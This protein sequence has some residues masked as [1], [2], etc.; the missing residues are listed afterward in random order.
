MVREDFTNTFF[1]NVCHI[2]ILAGGSNNLAYILGAKNTHIYKIFIIRFADFFL[3]MINAG[4]VFITYREL[5]THG[6]YVTG[7]WEQMLSEATRN[8]NSSRKYCSL[9]EQ[10][11]RNHTFKRARSQIQAC[12][13][14]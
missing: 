13:W 7:L 9:W 2:H 1:F 11:C 3:K 6:S 14:G 8:V 4:Y 5:C 10:G 12:C